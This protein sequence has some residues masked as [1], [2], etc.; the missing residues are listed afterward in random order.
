M[1]SNKTKAICKIG[2]DITPSKPKERI[3]LE[4]EVKNLE[5][6][7]EILNLDIED[8]Q[9]IANIPEDPKLI[10]HSKTDDLISSDE[11][12]EPKDTDPPLPNF[13]ATNLNAIGS[14]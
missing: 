12:E 9:N 3:T 4:C 10:N 13:N 14:I 1:D 6:D 7:A 5:S 8:S 2:K 11:V